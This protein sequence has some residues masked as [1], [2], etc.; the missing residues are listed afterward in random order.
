MKQTVSCRKQFVYSVN[1]STRWHAQDFLPIKIMIMINPRFCAKEQVRTVWSTCILVL[2]KRQ[3][4]VPKS[5]SRSRL[6]P[7]RSYVYNCKGNITPSNTGIAWMDVLA[8]IRPKSKVK[9]TTKFPVSM[10]HFSPFPENLLLQS[11]VKYK[12]SHFS[13]K[14]CN[15]RLLVQLCSDKCTR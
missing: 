2:W 10:P 9:L 12:D 11:L 15:G 7:W 8:Q 4:L 5:F 14:T 3:I 6:L 13:I 1:I